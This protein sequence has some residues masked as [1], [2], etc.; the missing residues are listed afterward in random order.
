MIQ[1]QLIN[2][3]KLRLQH[4]HVEFSPFQ[5]CALYCVR[6]FLGRT[7]VRQDSDIAR[8]CQKSAKMLKDMLGSAGAKRHI[9]LCQQKGL[10]VIDEAGN[11]WYE[12]NEKVKEETTARVDSKALHSGTAQD[13]QAKALP[14]PGG[15]GLLSIKVILI[16]I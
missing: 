5:R 6:C 9:A 16:T 7:R 10:V 13:A 3:V 14:G 1:I 15:S 4:F 11:K 2:C 12:F 8:K